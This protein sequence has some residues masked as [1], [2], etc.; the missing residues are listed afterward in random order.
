MDVV[1]APVQVPDTTVLVELYLHDTSGS[2]LNKDS[3]AAC[4]N[5]IYHAIL[6]YDVSSQES[7]D[8]CKLWLEELKK[9]RCAISLVCTLHACHTGSV[10]GRRNVAQLPILPVA[11]GQTAYSGWI[12]SAR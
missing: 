7:Y 5:G 9:A 6:V 11:P 1:V 4:W 10:V 8:A 12:G 3:L 2:D